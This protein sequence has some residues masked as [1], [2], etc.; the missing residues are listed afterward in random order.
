M[1]RELLSRCRTGAVR[2]PTPSAS[3][4]PPMELR[5]GCLELQSTKIR[6]KHKASGVKLKIPS[7]NSGGY[8]SEHL[9]V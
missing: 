5:A 7:G 8:P 4:R 6:I 3:A 1:Q 2:R 9:G